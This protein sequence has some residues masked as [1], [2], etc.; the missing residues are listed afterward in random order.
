[1]WGG[2]VINLSFPPFRILP[3]ATAVRTYLVAGTDKLKFPVKI[4]F[5]DRCL[6]ELP[7]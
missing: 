1:M 5:G 3:G 6:A 2:H 7:D 4:Y